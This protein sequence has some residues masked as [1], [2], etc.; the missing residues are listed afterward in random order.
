[1]RRIV[2]LF[3]LL[4]FSISNVLF[5]QSQPI[6]GIVIN[7]Q[8]ESLEYVSVALLNP[9]DSTL[10]NYTITD[11]KGFFQITEN[12]KGSLLLQLSLL[13]YKSYFKTLLYE[14]DVIDLKTITLEEEYSSLDEVMISAVIPIQIKKDTIAFNA[15]SFKV[16]HDDTIE[17]LLKK[18]PGVELDSDGKI[19]AQ[20]NEVTK[21]FVDGKEFFGGDPS[22]VLKNLSAD[23]VA[24]IEVIDKQSDESELTGIND[25]NKEVVIN[26]SLKK[27]KTNR[28]FGK[29]SAGMGLDSKYFSNLNYNKFS[30][31]TQLSVIGKF[32]N[33]NVTGSNIQG[34]LQ[35]ADGVDGSD[36]DDSND[37]SKSLSG[38]LKTGVTG[39]NV[40]HEFKK[41]ESINIDYFYNHSNNNGLSNSDRITFSGN[42]NFDYESENIFD[43]TSN[44]HNLN[45]NYENKSHKMH[46]LIIK[47]GLT[48]DKRDSYLDRKSSYLNDAGA[49]VTTNDFDLQND[50]DRKTGRLNV[51]FYQRLSKPGRSFSTIFGASTVN[52][53][54]N[55]FQNTFIT[56]NI[57]KTNE[58]SREQETL[59][60]E[61]VVTTQTSFNFNYTEPL[62]ENHYLKVN[63]SAKIKNEEE[64][65][66]QA[67]KT[68]TNATE[69]EFLAYTFQNKEHSYQTKFTHNYN[70]ETFNI[71]TGFELQDLNRAFGETD[72]K[73]FTKNQFYVNPL[74]TLNYTPK[75]GSKH[76][77][78]YKRVITSP[79]S[80]Q[81]TTVVNDLN[82]YS[83]RKGNPDLKTQKT[84]EISLS[85]TLH[86]FKSSSSFY[87][88]ILF[89]YSEDA[90]ISNINIDEDFV[91]TRSYEN[92]GNRKELNTLMSFTKKISSLGMR[93]T[94]KTKTLMKLQMP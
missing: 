79:R 29:V 30:S 56:R 53:D 88:R 47:G 91:R 46:R 43:N 36:E 80:S 33:I 19:I 50:I 5:S 40:G 35:N 18:L 77:L 1:M 4:S 16:N 74:F 58:S 67:R 28:G 62:W 92:K 34:F 87:S 83:I 64:N 68:I 61:A 60:D 48:S 51:N 54:F 55:N 21:I 44:K 85:N 25:G 71:T 10:I 81:I 63:T 7:P 3:I 42:N 23:A 72:K 90:I 69:E 15:S 24:K 37:N 20:G 73:T 26:F 41:K 9:K 94:F 66:D 38:Y 84:D 17:E 39:I 76:R 31:K 93:Y 27:T 57:G 82:P 13:G 78:M 49:L 11:S 2:I 89:K 45:F 32:N 65:A 59:R 52:S 8:N 86:D 22:I 70:K 14:N 6:K 75:K 12:A